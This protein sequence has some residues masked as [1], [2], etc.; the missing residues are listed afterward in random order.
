M[1]RSQ[2]GPDEGPL[3][4]PTIDQLTEEHLAADLIRGQNGIIECLFQVEGILNLLPQTA[5]ASN[6]GAGTAQAEEAQFNLQIH[7]RNRAVINRLFINGTNMRENLEERED[8]LKG[9]KQELVVALREGRELA[10]EPMPEW[11]MRERRSVDWVYG[12]EAP[13]FTEEAWAIL[14]FC[15]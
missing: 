1:D 11:W 2:S 3:A 12:L 4:I 10:K 8:L 6:T 13:L 15:E 7:P 14:E 5:T 9:R